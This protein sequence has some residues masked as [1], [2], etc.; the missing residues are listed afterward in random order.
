MADHNELL[1]DDANGCIGPPERT[2]G[3]TWVSGDGRPSGTSASVATELVATGLDLWMRDLWATPQFDRRLLM[4]G[5]RLTCRP[6]SFC[7]ER[8]RRVA[9][10]DS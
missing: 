4:A 5:D 7:S 9:T 8:Q 2:T 1:T 3:P 6:S 10:M